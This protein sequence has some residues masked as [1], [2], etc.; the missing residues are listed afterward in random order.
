MAALFY[1]PLRLLASPHQAHT[2][3]FSS[4][5]AGLGLATSTIGR[6]L[7]QDSF[8]EFGNGILKTRQDAPT[9]LG[10]DI[11]F[12][13]INQNI[14]DSVAGA[15]NTLNRPSTRDATAPS[16]LGVDVDQHQINDNLK[17]TV[18]GVSN[19]FKPESKRQDAPADPG[20]GADQDQI[21]DNLKS[22]VGGVDDV[23]RPS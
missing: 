18:D 5:A 21:N 23:F 17:S 16:D 3:K 2:M 20:I 12:E 14:I 8:K 22:T 10:I 9:D 19:I 7:L 1:S 4:V 13:Q 6:P 15:L 11:D